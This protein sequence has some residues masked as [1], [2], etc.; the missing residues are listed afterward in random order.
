M[1]GYE[2]GMIL[3]YTNCSVF[4]IIFPNYIVA[5]SFYKGRQYDSKKFI[6]KI[7]IHKQYRNGESNSRFHIK[8]VCNQ[9][10]NIFNKTLRKMFGQCLSLYKVIDFSQNIDKIA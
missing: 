5:F 2:P 1:C 4:L 3:R 8:R 6:H 10:N 7:N 9:E